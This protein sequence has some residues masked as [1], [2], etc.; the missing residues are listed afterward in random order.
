[1][2]IKIL[3]NQVVCDFSVSLLLDYSVRQF[4]KHSTHNDLLPCLP[5]SLIFFFFPSTAVF[6]DTYLLNMHP[7]SL[8]SLW[9]S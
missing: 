7:N 1:M 8:L 6:K 3:H 9:F 2:I 5:I 4:K